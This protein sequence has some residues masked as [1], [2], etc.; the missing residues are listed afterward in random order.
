MIIYDVSGANGASGTSGHSYHYKAGTG[1]HDG[2]PG[3]D[4]TDG[5]LGATAGTIAVRLTTPTTTANIPKNVVLAKPIDVDVK[6]EAS[7]V[8]STDRL[9]KTNTILK[10]NSGESICF[11]ALGGHG[12]KGGDGGDGQDGGTGYRYDTFLALFNKSISEYAWRTGDRMQLDTVTVL[13]AV[14]VA[15]EDVAVTQAEVVMEDLEEAFESLS[16]K[17]TL[18]SLYSMIPPSILAEEEVQQGDQG[19]EASLFRFILPYPLSKINFFVRRWRKGRG[20]WLLIHIFS[21]GWR[22]QEDIHKSW[23]LKRPIWMEWLEWSRGLARFGWARREVPH[24]RTGRRDR[25]EL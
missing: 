17:P 6:L 24:R 5:Q 7:V 23:W 25:L 18:I 10:I 13:M 3:G 12:G 22:K 21:R 19:W 8:F 4:G 15:M 9:Q 1:M 20:R 16:P 2:A 14:V 11:H